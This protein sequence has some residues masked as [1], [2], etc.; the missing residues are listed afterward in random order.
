MGKN[1]QAVAKKL[2]EDKDLRDRVMNA[3]TNDERQKILESAGLPMPS[4]TEI[5]NAKALAD[6]AG[7]QNTMTDISAS[8]VAAGAFV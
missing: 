1:F 8:V 2:N 7:A 4:D 5:K 6:V 3:S